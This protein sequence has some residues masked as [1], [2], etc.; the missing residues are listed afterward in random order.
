VS[1]EA[2][3]PFLIIVLLLE[4]TFSA[5]RSAL[6]HARI[7]QLIDQ[8]E[9]HP[10]SID[11]VLRLLERPHLRVGLRLSIALCHFLLGGLGWLLFLSLA[12][13]EP[14][15][16][17]AVA[18]FLAA[19]VIGL[20]IEF[21]VEGM[22]LHNPENWARRLA[23]LGEL[24][25]L[26]FRPMA[27]LMLKLL[28]SPAELKRPLGQVT[29][30]E[31]KSWVEDSQSTGGL[32]KDERKMIYSIFQFGDTLAREI[33]IP[34]IDVFSLDVNTS[35]PEAEMAVIQ[36]GHSRIPVYEDTIDNLLGLLYAKDLLK[37]HNDG[38]NGLRALLRP[39]YFVP[40]AKKVDDLLA[41]M[42]ANR[43]HMA[44]VVDEYGGVAGLVTMED[45]VEEIVGE[46]RDEYDQSEELQYQ[47]IS[48]DEIVFQGRIDIEDVNEL[49]GTHL[50]RE[51][52]DTLGGYLYG[53]IG[54]VPVG[55]EQVRVED[56]LLTVEQISGRRIRKVRA[57]RQPVQPPV[58]EKTDEAE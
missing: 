23:G 35:L 42:Q 19:A 31:L 25:E 45:I 43:V 56:W 5:V 20:L 4:F 52:A 44:V 50:T 10:E 30:D 15:P 21:G 37:A 27:W 48:P 54:R 26:V 16:W 18:I 2:V 34:R 38:V 36:S 58:E 57:L 22:V 7:P 46:I 24:V 33:M 47:E 6:I 39:V 51:V 55:G 29:D 28:G 41:E 9:D 12:V 40:E 11:R 14:T 53:E 13:V 49:L 32:E 17:M 8:R 1:S 3:L